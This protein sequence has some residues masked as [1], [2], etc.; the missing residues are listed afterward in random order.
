MLAAS[1]HVGEELL[2][3]RAVDAIRKAYPEMR[4]MICP[5]HV[6]RSVELSKELKRS[7][8]SFERRTGKSGNNDPDIFLIDTTGELNAWTQL[9]D[10]VIIGKSFL[11]K[12]GQN[13]AE[14]LAAGKPTITGPHMENFAALV[15][16]LKKAGGILTAET[17]AELPAMIEMAISSNAGEKGK[18]VL[19]SH[20]GACARTA[21]LLLPS[22]EPSP[23]MR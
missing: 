10:I 2:I 8:F 14:A 6:E 7:G 22:V 21:K 11:A 3:A 5:R 17:P 16:Q 15:I 18:A 19:E 12:G 4:L 20:R 1:T 9:A 13:P 23:G